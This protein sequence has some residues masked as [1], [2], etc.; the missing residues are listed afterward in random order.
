MMPPTDCPDC[1]ADSTDTGR[2]VHAD[3][4]PVGQA[5]DHVSQVDREWF[6]AHPDATEYRRDLLPGD[7]H[8][9]NLDAVLLGTDDGNPPRVRVRQVAEGVRVKSLPGNL[10]LR[11]D[12]LD[13]LR[14]VHLLTSAPTV[15]AE[16]AEVFRGD[17]AA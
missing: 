3:T 11:V 10:L 8:V 4:C 2:I 15:S 9:G 13:A 7:L 17:G 1:P 14:V 16:W 5:L 6:A 12:T